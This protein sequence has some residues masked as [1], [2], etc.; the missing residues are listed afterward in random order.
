MQ[1][2]LDV[3][4]PEDV[5][6]PVA[7]APDGGVVAAGGEPVEQDGQV[8]SVRRQVG[9]QVENGVR[10]HGSSGRAAVRWWMV[11]S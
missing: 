3:R 9:W 11:R 5:V 1:D 8:G 4:V 6:Q 7:V 2:G 10:G